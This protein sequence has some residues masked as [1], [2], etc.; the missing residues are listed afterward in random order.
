MGKLEKNSALTLYLNWYKIVILVLIKFPYR[1][2]M[3][4]QFGSKKF[5]GVIMKKSIQFKDIPYFGNHEISLPAGCTILGVLP[6]SKITNAGVLVILA[7]NGEKKPQKFQIYFSSTGSHRDQND[8]FEGAPDGHFMNV[9]GENDY[10][11]YLL[12]KAI[13]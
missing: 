2:V 10:V 6:R 1:L 7:D 4:L 8:I 9:F 11:L 12:Y 5:G 13:N 3:Y